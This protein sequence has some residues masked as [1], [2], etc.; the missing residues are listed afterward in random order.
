ARASGLP[1]IVPDRGGAH[2]QRLAGA[3]LSYA[4][5]DERAL[6]NAIRIFADRGVA[7]QRQRAIAAAGVRTMDQHFAALF[8]RYAALVPADRLRIA[9]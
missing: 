2:D 3:G 6:T 5:G 4:S 1:L 8:A 7:L 9:A